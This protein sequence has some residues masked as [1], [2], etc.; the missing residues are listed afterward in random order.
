MRGSMIDAIAPMTRLA[1]G[2]DRLAWPGV[3]TLHRLDRNMLA[4]FNVIARID[5]LSTKLNRINIAIVGAG[6][7]VCGSC[8]PREASHRVV[9]HVVLPSDSSRHSQGCVRWYDVYDPCSLQALA[10]HISRHST[11]RIQRGIPCAILEYNHYEPRFHI[12]S[13]H[14]PLLFDKFC[15]Q[16]EDP[17]RATVATNQTV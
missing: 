10:D 16:K 3:W 11:N 4:T 2:I 8:F 17:A 6:N 9:F 12:F 13:R 7:G 5:D 14:N 1:Q 15:S